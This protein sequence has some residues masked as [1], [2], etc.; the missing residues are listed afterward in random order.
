M[1]FPEPPRSGLTL[2]S[3]RLGALGLICRPGRRRSTDQASSDLIGAWTEG[4]VAVLS[5]R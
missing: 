3:D 2:R 1:I 4:P 5:A